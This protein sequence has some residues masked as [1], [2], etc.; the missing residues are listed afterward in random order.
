MKWL[1]FFLETSFKH[2]LK[3]NLNKILNYLN[4]FEKTLDYINLDTELL[5][6]ILNTYYTNVK[7]IKKTHPNEVNKFLHKFFQ[8]FSYKTNF[9]KKI[10]ISK[11]F[12]L[13]EKYIYKKNQKKTFEQTI[14]IFIIVFDIKKK[15]LYSNLLKNEN[16]IKSITNGN[17]LKEMRIKNKSKKKNILIYNYNIKLFME[18]LGKLNKNIDL[19]NIISH[20]N[21]AFKVIKFLK[22]YN[23]QNNTIIIKLKQ[24]FFKHGLK[25]IKS[26]KKKMRKR[27]TNK[28]KI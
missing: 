23:K 18:K 15:Q 21:K 4:V 22:K 26:I 6:N 14:D 28:Y 10:N 27:Y 12:V 1:N 19:I 5:L 11:K 24:N 16:I 7:I 25:K 9:L 20:R 8:N 2:P 3:R 13:Y 17:I